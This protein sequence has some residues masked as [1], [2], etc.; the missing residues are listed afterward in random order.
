MLNLFPKSIQKCKTGQRQTFHVRP[1]TPKSTK[2]ERV[3]RSLEFLVK[4]EQSWRYKTI[5][6]L[7]GSVLFQTSSNH[8]QFSWLDGPQKFEECHQKSSRVNQSWGR[9]VRATDL[10]RECKHEEARA[11]SF[12]DVSIQQ[13]CYAAC[14]SIFGPDF[15]V[16]IG[17]I[18]RLQVLDTGEFHT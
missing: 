6:C 11:S 18:F 9:K 16:R 14:Q 5:V 13:S 10:V 7:E 12:A 4:L 3:S 1:D 8:L 2:C 17:S 15:C